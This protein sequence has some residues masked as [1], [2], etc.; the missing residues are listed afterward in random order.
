[1]AR[2]EKSI[3][4]EKP[5]RMVYDQWTQFE[6][7][8]RFMEGV[9]EVHQIDDTT[10]HW[11]AKIG[12]K[13]EEW[14]AEIVQQIPDQSIAWRHTAGAIE[15]GRRAVHA[16]R[17]EPLPRDAALE[18]DPQGFVEKVGDALGFVSR[19]VE[20]DL[21]RF[22][23]FIEERGVETGAWRGRCTPATCIH[24][25]GDAEARHGRSRATRA[26]SYRLAISSSAA[27]TAPSPAW[28]RAPSQSA[29]VA[30]PPSAA[31]ASRWRRRRRCGTRSRQRGRAR[32]RAAARRRSRARRCGG[33]AR[34]RH[35]ALGD[36]GQAQRNGPA[37][38][39]V[40]VGGEAHDAVAGRLGEHLPHQRLVQRVAAL[41]AR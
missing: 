14:D 19:R 27:R 40:R 33:T 41:H 17:R 25:T 12:G 23:R 9:E 28:S 2:V 5:V 20:G 24:L 31:S 30:P 26:G 32:W 4:I 22:K 18:Y 37:R 21:E 36:L 34:C 38:R 16:A 15:R 6:E 8:P 11:V 10:L 7:F 35:P 13:R 29:G 1:M 3:E 39:D